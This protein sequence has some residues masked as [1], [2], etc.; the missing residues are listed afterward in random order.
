MRS[1][2]KEKHTHAVVYSLL[3]FTGVGT[4]NPFRFASSHIVRKELEQ[5]RREKMAGKVGNV[6]GWKHRLVH[7]LISLFAAH[8]EWLI[9]PISA[10][11]SI[12]IFYV[13]LRL[14]S[15]TGSGST[16]SPLRRRLRDPLESIIVY[17]WEKNARVVCEAIRHDMIPVIYEASL[18]S[19]VIE[20]KVLRSI[21]K[22]HTC[23]NFVTDNNSG[24]GE[25]PSMKKLN[26]VLMTRCGLESYLSRVFLSI[27]LLIHPSV[28]LSI[29]L[30]AYPLHLRTN[31]HTYIHTYIYT[32]IY[33]YIHIYV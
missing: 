23:W 21:R 18:V 9:H 20:M 12:A 2:V 14:L 25:P 10:N 5:T 4:T 17:L 7:G 22:D 3:R 28:C 29:H 8:L 31:T 27:C 1:D 11:V 16:P 33:I 26:F 19:S 15:A 30:F 32:Y 24:C 13:C 6:V